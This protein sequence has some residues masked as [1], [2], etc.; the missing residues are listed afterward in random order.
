MTGSV[1]KP[2][3]PSWLHWLG[4]YSDKIGPVATLALLLAV[5][6]LLTPRFWTVGNLKG[7]GYQTAS[8]AMVAI[9]E[10]IVIIS[11]GI[12]LSVGKLAVLCSVVTALLLAG[13]YPIPS[14][15]ALGAL[16][17]GAVG[18]L[19][20]AIVALAQMPS[21]VVTLGMMGI[22]YGAALLL[23]GGETVAGLPTVFTELGYAEAGGVPLSAW[24]MLVAAALMHVILTRTK[25]G[26]WTY[27]LGGNAQ[28]ARLSGVPVPRCQRAV[29][30]VCGLHAGVAGVL[31]AARAAVGNPTGGLNYELN[32]IA[33]VVIG[34][35]SL[36]GGE[37]HVGGTLAGALIMSVLANGLDH[38]GASP[39]LQ[40]VA[41][42]TVIIVAVFLDH[43]RRRGR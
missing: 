5:F 33:A 35:T 20:G 17:G 26:R 19:S 12:D 1:R 16:A 43:L 32:A 2:A 24:V 9:G 15:M 30:A 25:L 13:D 37:G 21:F 38:T 31:M 4:R 36:M 40:H 8:I 34:G 42:G 18:W 10:T 23:A 3:R 11:G 27:A 6:A 7:I 39:H 29:F 41:I 14:S 28:A 22:C